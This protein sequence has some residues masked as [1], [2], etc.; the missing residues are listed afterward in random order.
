MISEE[1]HEKANGVQLL[2]QCIHLIACLALTCDVSPNR[3]EY[4]GWTYRHRLWLWRN[5]TP[6]KCEVDL[7]WCIRTRAAH[8]EK[9]TV[10]LHMY[11]SRWMTNPFDIISRFVNAQ[12][13]VME[14]KSQNGQWERMV[15]DRDRTQGTTD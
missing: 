1:D 8:V 10:F 14:W 7:R 3:A 5:R 11:E 6:S 9:C 15:W 2:T 13:P 12:R 4:G